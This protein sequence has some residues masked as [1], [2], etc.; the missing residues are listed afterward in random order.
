MS[1]ASCT[2]F[3][4]VDGTII[5]H[6]PGG[7]VSATVA[8]ARP[9]MGVVRA[10]QRLRERGHRTFICTGRPLCLIAESLLEL[11]S[12][13][14][15]SSAGACVSVEG[16]VLFDH[17]IEVEL[18]DRLLDISERSLVPVLFEGTRGD[19][20]YVP[21]GVAYHSGGNFPIVHSREEMERR[22]DM[23]FAKFVIENSDLE[24]FVSADSSIFESC[25]D[26]FD[27]GL[28]ISEFSVKGIDKGYGVR[29]ALDKLGLSAR[30]TI[31]FGDSENDLPM[32][33]AVE[34]FVA[35]GNAMPAV[36][37]RSAYVTDSVQDDG[38]VT[39]LEHFGLL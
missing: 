15:I 27:L 20:A 34:T 32:A 28:G 10:F 14:I 17:T 38:V 5:Y 9:S 12:T 7:D 35:M 19:A 25:F 29:R 39:A 16:D 31:A 1:E 21:Q 24:T 37:E 22:A 3:F 13:G 18:I 36:K 6:E 26:G 8:N 2:L 30:G 33:D 4:D 23:R 11:H